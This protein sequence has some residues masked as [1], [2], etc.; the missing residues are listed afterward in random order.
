MRADHGRIQ[1]Q[2]K[3][4]GHAYDIRSTDGSGEEITP[5]LRQNHQCKGKDDVG[6]GLPDNNA[7]VRVM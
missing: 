7:E 5:S 6:I 4:D 2:N 3:R 1:I